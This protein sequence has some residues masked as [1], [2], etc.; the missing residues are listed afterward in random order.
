M[1]LFQA[2]IHSVI[3]AFSN[4]LPVGEGAHRELLPFLL[5][6]PT[7]T[8]AVKAAISVGSACGAF[9]YFWHDWASMLSS[10]AQVVV[11]RRR[12]RTMDERMPLFVLIATLPVIAGWFYLE[13]LIPSTWNG[14]L[15]TLA[16]LA[17]GSL[18]LT[19]LEGYSRKNRQIYDWNFKDSALAGIGQLAFLFAGL[20]RSWGAL[21]VAFMRNHS[22]ESAGKYA[23]YLSA[24]VLFAFALRDIQDI[25][26]G[27]PLADGDGTSWLIFGCCA[28]ISLLVSLFAVNALNRSSKKEG[29][30]AWNRYRWLVCAVMGTKLAF[31]WWTQ[32]G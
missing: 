4:I 30:A 22:R 12:P 1:T 25:Q 32:S 9:F 13:P 31:D 14:P 7:A 28:G 8:P 24:P 5:G 27:Q 16:Y 2:L 17:G 20:G 6:W 3:C 26:F 23:I 29:F 21:T 19:W 15:P 10:V 11:F 18:L